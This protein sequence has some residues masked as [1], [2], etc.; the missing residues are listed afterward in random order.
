MTKQRTAAAAMHAVNEATEAVIQSGDTVIEENVWDAA[1][2]ALDG[3]PKQYLVDIISGKAEGPYKQ[4]FQHE[5]IPRIMRL[6]NGLHEPF[7][8]RQGCFFVPHPRNRT[9]WNGC[10]DMR[11]S[12]RFLSLSSPIAKRLLWG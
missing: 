5:A 7:A 4:P 9:R 12:T 1:E 10:S 8:E 2:A 11:P 3:Q 6:R